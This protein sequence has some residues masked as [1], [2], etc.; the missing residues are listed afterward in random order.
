MELA[1]LVILGLSGMQCNV[2]GIEW[3][4]L[5]SLIRPIAVYCDLFPLLPHSKCQ[6][7]WGNLA[8]EPYRARIFGGVLWNVH[9]CYEMRMS[10]QDW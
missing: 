9:N 2:D 10:F 1:Q 5:V 4:S 3:D 6:L 8:P 7:K